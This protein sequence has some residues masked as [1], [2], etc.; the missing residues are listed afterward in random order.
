MYLTPPAQPG[1]LYYQDNQLSGSP[2]DMIHINYLHF[3]RGLYM[4][5]MS[6]E[7]CGIMPEKEKKDISLYLA[8]RHRMAVI[9]EQMPEHL[10]PSL[11]RVASI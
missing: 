5:S 7:S 8:A 10:R 1:F 11:S 4:S 2:N 3:V 9:A 6:P